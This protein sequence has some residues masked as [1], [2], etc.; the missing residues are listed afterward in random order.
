MAD[1][2]EGGV[3]VHGD[4]GV[5]EGDEWFLGFGSLEGVVCRVG[6]RVE[7]FEG[8]VRRHGSAGVAFRG[9]GF[10]VWVVGVEFGEVN[11]Q[12]VG[13]VVAG[14]EVAVQAIV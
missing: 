10:W 13:E 6:V 8:Q 7:W 14:V 2:E 12:A 5:D 1:G 9:S 3:D 11:V 4:E